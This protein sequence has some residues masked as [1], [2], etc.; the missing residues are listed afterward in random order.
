MIISCNDNYYHKTKR[1]F[2][3]RASEHL[4]ITLLNGKKLKSPK[5]SAVFDH[6]FH[7]GHDASFNDFETFVKESDEFR[8]LLRQSLLILHDPLLNRNFKSIPSELF[9]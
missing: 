7:T 3:V 5:E 1:R 4:S 2:K 8:L 9:S 6:I